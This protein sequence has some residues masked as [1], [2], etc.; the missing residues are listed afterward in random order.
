MTSR[1]VIAALERSRRELTIAMRHLDA[2]AEE[3]AKDVALAIMAVQSARSN[4]HDVLIAVRAALAR[5][6]RGRESA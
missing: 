1:Q 2:I 5:G 6:P 3:G 4:L